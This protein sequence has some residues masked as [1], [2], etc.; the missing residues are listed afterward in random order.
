MVGIEIID[1]EY[2]PLQFVGFCESQDLL[3]FQSHRSHEDQGQL[4]IAICK[5]RKIVKWII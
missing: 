2:S 1:E 4:H 5:S 3:R